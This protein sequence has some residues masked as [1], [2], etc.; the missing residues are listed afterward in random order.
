ML[1]VKFT[2]GEGGKLEYNVATVV[3]MQ[4]L[5]KWLM[6]T[7]LDKCW[8]DFD[9][10]SSQGEAPGKST[11]WNNYVWYSVPAVIYGISNNLLI[12]DISLLGPSLF[13][14][15]NNLKIV[16]TTL[17]SSLV[18]AKYFTSIQ[19]IAVVM[20]VI[21]FF[22]AKVDFLMDDTAKNCVHAHGLKNDTG[23]RL[24]SEEMAASLEAAD[25]SRF[26]L[27]LGL[28]VV[29]S[30][31]SASAAISNEYL[32]KSVDADVSFMRKNI[33]TYQWGAAVNFAIVVCSY[34]KF[35]MSEDEIPGFFQGYSIP[36]CLLILNNALMGLSASM[37][38]KYFDN[39]VRCFAGSLVVYF[40]GA[41][42]YL[43]FGSSTVNGPFCLGVIIFSLASFLYMGSHNDELPKVVIRG[44]DFLTLLGCGAQLA[45]PS[46]ETH[47]EDEEM[48]SIVGKETGD[49]R[50]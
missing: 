30:L 46:N 23:A 29:L 11:T 1:V 26:M 33:W 28:L 12:Y 22:V 31:L 3:L 48:A 50:T 37:V 5:L 32:L 6:A 45:T 9:S 14:L 44:S 38:M 43:Y 36:V 18:L 25:A 19:W 15:F 49:V 34:F 8:F 24:L 4:E 16:S 35:L 2:Q 40:V 7:V 21:S 20:L 10:S 47:D 17:L 13:S 39:I 42:S 27:G 41:F